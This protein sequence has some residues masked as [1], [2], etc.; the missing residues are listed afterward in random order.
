MYTYSSPERRAGPSRGHLQ[1]GSCLCQSLWSTFLIHNLQSR[2]KLA[3]TTCTS[4]GQL[5]EG[6]VREDHGEEDVHAHR[7][8]YIDKLILFV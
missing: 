3:L 2:E 5:Q 4:R 1:E 7:G 8:R 6:E